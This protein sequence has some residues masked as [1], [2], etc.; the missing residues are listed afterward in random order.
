MSLM[1]KGN[2]NRHVGETNMNARS[3]RSH[4]VFCVVVERCSK[5][6]GGVTGVVCS[7]LNLID[8]AGSER[9]KVQDVCL[10]VEVLGLPAGLSS[11][12]A[13]QHRDSLV[14]AHGGVRR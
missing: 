2:R 4:C 13:P 3:S 12:L 8:L 10:C 9:I 1:V 14:R 7:R 5:N 11:V 6:A